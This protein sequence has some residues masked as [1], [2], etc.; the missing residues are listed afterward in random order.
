MLTKKTGEE[1]CMYIEITSYEKEE[2]MDKQACL[3]APITACM[4]ADAFVS[5]RSIRFDVNA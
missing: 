5:A 1:Y 4:A 3:N 2:R